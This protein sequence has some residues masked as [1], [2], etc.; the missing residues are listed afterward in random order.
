MATKLDH[1]YKLLD[2]LYLPV[3]K[4]KV[5]R[6]ENILHIPYLDNRR[7][8]KRSYVEWGHVIGIFETLFCI[9]LTRKSDNRILDLGCGTGILGIAAKQFVKNGEYIGIDVNENDIAFCQRQYNFPNYSFIA[10]SSHNRFYSPKESGHQKLAAD[11]SSID[12]VTA[13]SVWTHFLKEDAYFYLNEVRRVLKK[14]GVAIITFF[15]LDDHYNQAKGLP[16]DWVFEK[17][18]TPD[19]SWRTAHTVKLP[20]ERVGVTKRELDN[21]I[22]SVGLRIKEYYPGKWKGS[23]GAYFQDVIILEKK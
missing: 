13:L 2:R 23:P 10:S 20:E 7:G 11:D 5:K 18:I 1:I 17:K 4:R 12:M 9:H 6:A 15:Y 14:D 21:L 19:G 3:D 22:D 8:G 16:K